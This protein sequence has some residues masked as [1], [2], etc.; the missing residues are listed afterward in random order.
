MPD[1]HQTALFELHRELGARMVQFAGYEMPLHYAN[2]V[3]Q[4]HLHTRTE[5]GL[6]DV[7]HMGQLQLMGRHAATALE[8][9]APV[10]IV[11]LAPNQ[12]RY[13]LFTDDAG[14]ILDDF[15]VT[16]TGSSLLLVV[17][18]GCKAADTMHLRLHLG[19]RCEIVEMQQ[20]ALLALQGPKAVCVMQRL[21]PNVDFSRWIFMSARKLSLA[22]AECLVTRSGYTGEDGFEISV[23]NAHAEV[24]ARTLLS[25][26]EV[27][28]IGLGARDSLRLEAGLCLYG[29]DMDRSTSPIEASLSWAISKARRM[30]GVREGGFPGASVIHEQLARG[31]TRKRVGLVGREQAL[32]REGAILLSAAG[33]TIGRVTSGG[34]GPSLGSAIAMGYVPLAHA[35]VGTNLFG[36][37]R[38]R[39]VPLQV[40]QMPFSPA[41]Y[42]RGIV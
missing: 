18:A 15:M 17:N 39:H 25:E 32:L 12:Q 8:S 41:R 2:G 35:A 5:A 13:A 19:N 3:L 40:V 20:H 14:G 26:P 24:V 27:K 11:D 42:Y 37:V 4:E 9:L 29:H 7:S 23:E 16:H 28:P 10:D 22:K 30:A 36:V 31:V 38:Q 21:V 6:F 33:E 34:F 1:S